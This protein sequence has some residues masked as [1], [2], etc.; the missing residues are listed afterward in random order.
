MVANDNEISVLYFCAIQHDG[1]KKN[2]ASENGNFNFSDESKY[3]TAVAS[4]AS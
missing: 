2:I 4:N 1:E 3:V